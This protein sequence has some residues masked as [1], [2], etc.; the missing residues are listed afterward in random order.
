[1]HCSF[2]WVV[3]GF[4][5]CIQSKEDSDRQVIASAAGS[6]AFNQVSSD[7]TNRS[8]QL[9]LGI[10]RALGNKRGQEV[11]INLS[12]QRYQLGSYSET[13]TAIG[14]LRA[15]AQDLSSTRGEL[16]YRL[17]LDSPVPVVVDIG[18]SAVLA[19]DANY[20]VMEQSSSLALL[21]PVESLRSDS[22]SLALESERFSIG[23]A[24]SGQGQ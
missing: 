5:A 2:V 14:A 18:Y 16:F 3:C 1:M 9:Q 23:T 19:S 21:L 8:A 17:K 12:E 6:V 7:R 22:Y 24:M 10:S 20:A 11:V 15:S 13:G 4:S